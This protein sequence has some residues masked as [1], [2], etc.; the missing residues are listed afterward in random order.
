MDETKLEAIGRLR[1][2]LAETHDMQLITFADAQGRK[3]G[4]M[5]G[6]GDPAAT[7]AANAYNFLAELQSLRRGTGDATHTIRI[8]RFE[9]GPSYAG[10]PDKIGVRIPDDLRDPRQID[11]T[12]QAFAMVDVVR[13][14]A[15]RDRLGVGAAE[16]GNDGDAEDRAEQSHGRLAFSRSGAER[17]VRLRS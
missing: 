5:A 1:R 4:Q 6:L 13:Q 2:D 7:A 17:C 14:D 8:G 12:V 11:P 15:D 9:I 10:E 3:R 16:Q